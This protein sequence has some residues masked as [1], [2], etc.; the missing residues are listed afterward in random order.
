MR[1]AVLAAVLLIVSSALSAGEHE[2][3]GRLKFDISPE[4]QTVEVE[5]ELYEIA[6]YAKVTW[7]P[8]FKGG[9]YVCHRAVYF[10]I[11]GDLRKTALALY[12]KDGRIIGYKLISIHERVL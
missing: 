10:I 7:R 9:R 4:T 11:G 12:R 1:S 8:L 3:L 6:E 2:V 5:G